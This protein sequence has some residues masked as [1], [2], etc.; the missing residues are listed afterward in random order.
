MRREHFGHHWPASPAEHRVVVL[1]ASPKPARYAN[2]ALRLLIEKGYQAVPVHPR[3]E[4]IE[5]L[6]VAHH[7]REIREPVHTLALYVGPQR[8][9]PM[10]ADILELNPG[11][12]IFN[13]GTESAL[14][15]ERLRAHH[16]ECIHGCTLVMLRTAQF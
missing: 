2:Q 14:L 11:R 9:E 8:S 3:I 4:R 1:G 7:L 10:I 12:V 15:E 13:P 5:G 6:P 16:I